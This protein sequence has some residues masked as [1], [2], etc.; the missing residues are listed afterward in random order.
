[1]ITQ[2]QTTSVFIL[3]SLFLIT[4][5][6]IFQL[7]QFIFWL[8]IIL[9]TKKNDTKLKS[10]YQQAL[11]NENINSQIV[12][13]KFTFKYLNYNFK[14]NILKLKSRDFNET[15]TWNKYQTLSSV[16]VIKWK[17]NSQ[18][19]S[20]LAL[21]IINLFFI[22]GVIITIICALLYYIP[23]Q[24][25]NINK[26]ILAIFSFLSLLIITMSWLFW[27]MFYEKFR[28]QLM[29]L[30]TELNYNKQ[31]TIKYITLFKSCFPFS[32]LMF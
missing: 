31:K 8:I 30:N 20:N 28:K 6:L 12:K 32:D 19:W 10:S 1:M 22:N 17:N 18:K 26:E 21:P 4:M 5:V 2:D 14:K 24:N 16:L 9:K 25:N 11:S 7:F 13:S 29:T 15:T 27:T 23:I 3:I